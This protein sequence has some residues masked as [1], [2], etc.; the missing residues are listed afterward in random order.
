MFFIK[1]RKAEELENKINIISKRKNLIESEANNNFMNN[2]KSHLY[3]EK[4][5]DK[6]VEMTNPNYKNDLSKNYNIV[7]D[8]NSSPFSYKNEENNS[9]NKFINISN[10]KDD[11]DKNLK[12]ISKEEKEKIQDIN[13]RNTKLRSFLK[14]IKTENKNIKDKNFKDSNFRII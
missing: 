10:M 4:L 3:K 7:S 8:K 13:N 5:N 6:S 14:Q 12:K 2:N 9:V 1:N 11:N